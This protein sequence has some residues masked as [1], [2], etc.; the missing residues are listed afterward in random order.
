MSQQTRAAWTEEGPQQPLTITVPRELKSPNRWNGRHWRYKHR[1]TQEWEQAVWVWI[2][3]AAGAKTLQQVLV[4]MNAI[5]PKRVCDEKRVV[6]VTRLVPSSR[7]FIRDDDNLRFATKPL[8]DALKRLGL[9]RDDNR[10]WLEQ[11]MPLQEV[12]KTGG[13]ATVIQIASAEQFA[14]LPGA[15]HP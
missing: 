1:E 5:G 6:T 4:S 8:N 3:K 10:K 11:P 13:W 15:D 7:N 14:D 2:A 9:I 12:S